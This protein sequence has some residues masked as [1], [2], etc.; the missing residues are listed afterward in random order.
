[1]KNLIALLLIITPLIN[2]A[3]GKKAPDVDTMYTVLDSKEI[4]F[5][6]GIE[7]P[8]N[9]EPDFVLKDNGKTMDMK[10]DKNCDVNDIS[11]CVSLY[12]LLPSKEDQ[13]GN[14]IEGVQKGKGYKWTLKSSILSKD[15]MQVTFGQKTGEDGPVTYS[16]VNVDPDEIIDMGYGSV[17]SETKRYVWIVS[18]SWN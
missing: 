8:E 9:I 15:E 7:A 2:F 1:M 12:H 6:N 10:I 17:D 14:K 18:A 16:T 4:T 13:F 11:T 3:Q 5:F